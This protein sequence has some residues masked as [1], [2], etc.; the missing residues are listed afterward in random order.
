[1]LLHTPDKSRWFLVPDEVSLP[2]GD[3][4]VIT[5]TRE[6]RTVDEAVIVAFEV[7]PHEAREWL[8]ERF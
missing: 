4:S 6:P 3:L 8:D 7:E 1:M 5:F 2:D